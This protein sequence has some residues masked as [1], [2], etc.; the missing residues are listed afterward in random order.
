MPNNILKILRKAIRFT[1]FHY[2]LTNSRRFISYLRR[3]G[4]K[5]GTNCIFREPKTIRI[6]MTRPYLISIGNNVDMNRYFQI[7]THDWASSVFIHKYGQMINSS[8]KVIIGNNIYFGANVTVLKGVT[9]GDNCIIGACSVVN[10]DIPA[11]SVAVGNP[12]KIVCSLDEYFCKR[13]MRSLFEAVELVNCFIDRNG[14]KPSGKDLLEEHIFF[15]GN[16][17]ELPYTFNSEK[18]FIEFC[19]KNKNFHI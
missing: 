13:K 12:C 15:N 3:G 14:K 11:N 17:S 8:G 10:K 16:N 5:I 6:D 1:Y 2:A 9:I 18:D 7:W 19:I 4:V